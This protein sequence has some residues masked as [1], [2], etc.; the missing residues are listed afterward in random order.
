MSRRERLD[1]V[2]AAWARDE[3][4]SLLATIRAIHDATPD[5]GLAHALDVA[6][7]ALRRGFVATGLQKLERAL[8]VA[9]LVVQEESTP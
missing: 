1:L 8:A 4:S 6:A 7:L 9:E 5:G 3:A 2:A